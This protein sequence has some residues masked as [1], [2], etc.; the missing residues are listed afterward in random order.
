[1]I[2]GVFLVAPATLSVAAEEHVNYVVTCCPDDD[3]YIS[4]DPLT[5]YPP[6]RHMW[7]SC[8]CRNQ[9]TGW[10]FCG[11]SDVG[12]AQCWTCFFDCRCIPWGVVCASGCV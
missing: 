12:S 10:G 11:C 3:A 4:I 2:L 1:M 5:N 9:L 6:C 7:A 8:Q